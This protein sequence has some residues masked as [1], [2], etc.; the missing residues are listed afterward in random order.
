MAV[1]ENGMGPPLEGTNPIKAKAPFGKF[2]IVRI[3]QMCSKF[4]ELPVSDSNVTLSLA[5]LFYCKWS[6]LM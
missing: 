6:I 3:F 5:L 2:K 1:N 4:H